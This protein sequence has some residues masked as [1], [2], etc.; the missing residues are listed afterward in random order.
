MNFDSKFWRW[1][2]AIATVIGLIAGGLA[3]YD[4]VTEDPYTIKYEQKLAP[5]QKATLDSGKPVRKGVIIT[6]KEASP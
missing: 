2:T 4:Y 3:L 6:P 5:G 1:F